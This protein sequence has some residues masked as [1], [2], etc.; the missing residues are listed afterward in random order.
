MGKTSLTKSVSSS[1]EVFGFNVSERK[2]YDEISKAR[3]QIDFAAATRTPCSNKLL[4]S[5][6]SEI[7]G[8]FEVEVDR[9]M[10]HV[11]AKQRSRQEATRALLDEIDAL[12]SKHGV[13]L[14]E[15]LTEIRKEADAQVQKCLK[16]EELTA[17]STQVL[18]QIANRADQDVGTA[19][20]V[21]LRRNLKSINNT[22][23]IEILSDL[24]E[25]IRNAEKAEKAEH[26]TWEAP[27]T[28]ERTTSKYWVEEDKLPALLMVAATEAPLMVYGKNGRLT[29]KTASESVTENETIWKSLASPIASVY[30]D[31]PAMDL[32][33]QR[34]KRSEGAKLLRV[35]WYGKRMPR[36]SEILFLELKTH[37]ESWICDRSVKERV[38]I[39]EKDIRQFLAHDVWTGGIAADIVSAASPALKGK[40]LEDATALLNRMHEMV[41]TYDLRPC[42]RSTYFRAAFQSPDSNNLRL[43]VDHQVTLVDETL[44]WNMS[45]WCLP[46]DADLDPQHT[47]RIPFPVFEIKLADSDIPN[48]MSALI[49]TGVLT[50]AEKFSKFLTGAAAFR[51]KQLDT[52]PHWVDHPLFISLLASK[53]AQ[54]AIRETEIQSL[55][56]RQRRPII[57]DISS[58]EETSSNTSEN[59][60]APRRSSSFRLNRTISRDGSFR[61]KRLNWLNALDSTTDL[62]KGSTS[63][64]SGLRIAPKQRVKVEPKTY[65]A[66]ERTFIQ[67]ISAALLL[68][69]VALILLEAHDEESGYSLATLGAVLN[70]C[71]LVVAAYSIF[72]YF[73]RI[74]LIKQGSAFGYADYIGP[75]IL[76]CAVFLGVVTLFVLA[77]RIRRMTPYSESL[78]SEAVGIHDDSNGKCKQHPLLGVS[79]LEFQP[80]SLVSD[81]S[82]DIL[83][84]AS[85]DEI[86]ATS[87]SSPNNEAFTVAKIPYAKSAALTMVHKTLFAVS[88]VSTRLDSSKNG[89]ELIAMQWGA[90]DELVGT[91][92]WK[93]KDRSIAIAYVPGGSN[94]NSGSL[95]V[96]G[97]GGSMDVYDV[98]NF[99][100]QNPSSWIAPPTATSHST[101]LHGRPLNA[102]L[103][104]EGLVDP[105]IA[106][107][108]YFEGLLYVMHD[109]ERVVRVWDIEQGKRVSEWKLPFTGRGWDK[110]WKGLSLERQGHDGGTSS[111]RGTGILMLHLALDTPAQV[112]SLIVK[113]DATTKGRIHF[114]SCAPS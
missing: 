26:K 46:D 64:A 65:F 16:L 107:I 9:V 30:F 33:R 25:A 90:N 63:A 21:T 10:V 27:T 42:V 105:N 53:P 88:Q 51:Q 3:Q 106:A 72:V 54:S 96:A 36:G 69:T 55:Y 41:V 104:G 34:I 15:T 77:L 75:T 56:Q 20:Q 78:R 8:A 1:S 32:Y 70:A 38:A 39:Q 114:P 12:V 5:L 4:R 71:A 99:K 76:I 40:P 28:F 85:H 18:G 57:S 37:H 84:V 13:L 97:E 60:N 52:L 35:R 89:D 49:E 81:S 91:N 22:S 59:L 23:L 19:C 67:W 108:Q 101:T 111:L 7:L 47:L 48:S 73:R 113:E 80:S 11:S 86:W 100:E 50:E 2:L 44:S 87:K 43:T 45:S 98:P 68:V 31:S 6:K 79:R 110:N 102:N 58:T 82:R 14:P 103:L 17:N 61:F 62:T 93:I 74:N 109:R 66:N 112:W 24:Y 95:Y 94:S 92:R 83:M 29:S